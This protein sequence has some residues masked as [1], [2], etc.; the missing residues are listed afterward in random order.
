M[1]YPFSYGRM[2]ELFLAHG[3]YAQWPPCTFSSV[4]FG[5]TLCAFPSLC[6]RGVARLQGSWTSG[7]GRSCPF[8]KVAERSVA[9]I[10]FP[11]CRLKR[12]APWGALAVAVTVPCVPVQARSGL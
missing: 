5:W 9:L 10:R 11:G 8:S 6:G 2:F 12:L 3:N 7:F 1:S 4:L